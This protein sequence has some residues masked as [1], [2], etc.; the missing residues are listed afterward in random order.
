MEVDAPK[1]ALECQ[2]GGNARMARGVESLSM[3]SECGVR[4]H[5]ESQQGR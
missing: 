1:S 2:Y 3:L 4:Y 5:D